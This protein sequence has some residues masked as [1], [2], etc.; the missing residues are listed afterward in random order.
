MPPTSHPSS[1][2]L[3]PSSNAQSFATA[4][5]PTRTGR[6]LGSGAALSALTFGVARPAWSI[7]RLQRSV[8]AR[9]SRPSAAELA[10]LTHVLVHLPASPYD[11]RIARGS[12][13]V[14]A[15]HPLDHDGKF[16][17]YY[18]GNIYKAYGMQYFEERCLHGL[19]V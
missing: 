2:R 13:I 5:A 7:T 10:R 3:R 18:E 4:S 15:D 19:G 1:P 17:V 16:L 12:A 6:T 11:G 14:A 8:V 9:M